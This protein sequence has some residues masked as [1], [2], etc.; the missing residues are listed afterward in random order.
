MKNLFFKL[1]AILEVVAFASATIALFYIVTILII[2]AGSAS[3]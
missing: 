1:G 3:I 2:N